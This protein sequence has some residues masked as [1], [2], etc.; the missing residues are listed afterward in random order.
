MV[1]LG[2]A[3]EIVGVSWLPGIHAPP[4]KVMST[5]T[6]HAIKKITKTS[7]LV[8]K[9]LKAFR[10]NF[11]QYHADYSTWPLVFRMKKAY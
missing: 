7:N 1:Y 6:F 10:T 3:L 11:G 8:I 2:R 4:A 9:N 5:I